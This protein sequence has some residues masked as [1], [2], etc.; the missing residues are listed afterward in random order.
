M[1]RVKTNFDRNYEQ[2][3]YVEMDN[4]EFYWYMMLIELFCFRNNCK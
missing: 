1:V 3:F 2:D 4:E